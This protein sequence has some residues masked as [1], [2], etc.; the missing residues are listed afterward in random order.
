ME[1]A[2]RSI[3]VTESVDGSGCG[4]VNTTTQPRVAEGFPSCVHNTPKTTYIV[5]IIQH[6]VVFAGE[7]G[8]SMV[9]QCHKEHTCG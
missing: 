5:R 9:L 1:G 3:I 7:H 2:R 6:S 4:G 8:R